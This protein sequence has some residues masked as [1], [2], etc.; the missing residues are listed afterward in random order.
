MSSS[1]SS[2]QNH[3]DVAIL[4]GGPAGST[5]GTFLKMHDPDVRVVILEKEKFP[6]EHVGESQLP[7]ISGILEEMGCWHKVEA[8]DFP[9]KVGATYRWGSSP[10][11]W[12][13]EF[14]PMHLFRDEPRPAQREGWRK[15]T[16]FQ[17]DRAKYDTI[18]L[19]HA[20]ETG[21]EVFQETKVNEVLRDGDRITGLRLSGGREITAQFYLDCSGHV[22]VI[23]RAMGIEIDVPTR[24]RNM[25]LWDYW[26]NAEWAAEI[27]VGGTRVQV[28][29]IGCGWIWFIPLGPTRTS[30]G[31]ICPADYYREVGKSPEELYTWALAQEKRV[32]ALTK[33]AKREGELRATKDWSFVSQRMA[34]ENW[35]LVGEAAGFADPILAGGMTL[36]HT[37]AR[38]C[39]FSI[40]SM[41]REEEDPA[42]LK[43]HYQDI[44]QRRI[45]QY[46]RFADFWYATNG[47]FESLREY[48]T[49]IAKGAGLKLKPA[50][51]FRWLSLG[52]FSHEDWFLPGLGGL[53]FNAVREVTRRFTTGDQPPYEFS[54]YNVLKLNLVGAREEDVP[55]YTG[56]KVIRAKAYKRGGRILPQIG[57]YGS[58]IEV[59]RNHSDVLDIARTFARWEVNEQAIGGV[60]FSGDQALATVESMLLEGWI[61][62]RVNKKKPVRPLTPLASDG[63]RSNFHPNRDTIRETSPQASGE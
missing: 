17:V 36:A 2:K 28:L 38:E 3:Y 63:E 26:E 40:L 25:A 58:V 19:D 9:I 44:Q 49:E 23:R 51:A 47:N 27:G 59:L 21:C 14:L 11:L 34:G 24:L 35:F 52:G 1:K 15:L 55:V 13:F 43:F 61:T 20:R 42:W 37:S 18:L 10:D 31:F 50:D 4:G 60:K 5:A 54:K 62:G 8:A 6:R 12:D 32:T 56:G 33:N 48:T 16:A 7:P 29:S 46:I 22:G 53:D 57:M 45:R 39:A 30:I 41:L